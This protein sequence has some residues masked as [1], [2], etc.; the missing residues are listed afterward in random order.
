MKGY[1]PIKPW[2]SRYKSLLRRVARRQK[3]IK[4]FGEATRTPA[5]WSQTSKPPGTGGGG[6][7]TTT[8]TWIWLVAADKAAGTPWV[9]SDSEFSAGIYK[10]LDFEIAEFEELFVKVGPLSLPRGSGV[11]TYAHWDFTSA[12]SITIYN[13]SAFTSAGDFAGDLVTVTALR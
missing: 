3:Q 4:V 1:Q 10:A 7:G 8:E 5:A 13:L 9:V 6:G 11:E 12:T 2:D